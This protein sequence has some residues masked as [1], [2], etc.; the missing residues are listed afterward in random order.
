[1]RG[2]TVLLNSVDKGTFRVGETRDSAQRRNL[3]C[4]DSRVS[5]RETLALESAT[6]C[7]SDNNVSVWQVVEAKK[8]IP[9]RSLIRFSNL[10]IYKAMSAMADFS[11]EKAIYGEAGVEE[12]LSSLKD[13]QLLWVERHYRQQYNVLCCWHHC[14]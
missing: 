6:L 3:H 5:I 9:E 14:S 4:L 11:E 10:N 12:M 1:M 13:Q 8:S 2:H 7:A